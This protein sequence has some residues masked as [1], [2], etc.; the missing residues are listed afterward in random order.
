MTM[1]V[2]V[3]GRQGYHEDTLEVV[4]PDLISILVF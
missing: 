3:S 4:E 1:K 2:I